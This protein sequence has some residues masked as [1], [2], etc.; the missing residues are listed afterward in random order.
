MDTVL[1]LSMTPTTVGLVLVEGDGIDSSTRSHDAFGARRGGF[2]PVTTSAFVAEALSRTQAIAQGQR[3]QAIRVTWSDDAAIEASLLLES[4]AD[5]G[6]DNV[7]PIRLPEATEA[8][9][10]GIGEVIGSDVTAVCVIESDTAIVLVVDGREAHD[11]PGSMVLTA[12]SDRLQCENDLIDWVSEVLDRDGWQPDGL[13]L[14]GAG[15]GLNII[16]GTLQGILGIPVFAPAEAELALA[17]GA[18]LTQS[19]PVKK[20]FWSMP[21]VPIAMLI[22]GIL[23]FVVSASLAVGIELLPNRGVGN[24]ETIDQ[25]VV[26]TAETPTKLQAPVAPAPVAP[27]PTAEAPQ[28]EAPQTEAP[29]TES[30]Q[31]EST[32]PA[33]SMLPATAAQTML[34]SPS[35]ES[36]APEN[37]ESVP[38]AD[39]P[40]PADAS[41]P[42]Q[43]EIPPNG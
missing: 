38:A 18:A 23:T 36:P 39:M 5:M 27:V 26:N 19:A 30:A 32:E 11:A 34:E 40:A 25:H 37:V 28:T 42:P 41:S 10:R 9:A 29:Q 6:F 20:P 8:F 1:G 13:V 31:D 17:R 21:K 12:V 33:S 7:V 22:G 16:A 14:L 4:L 3:L 43:V 35:L 24:I 2:S 15:D